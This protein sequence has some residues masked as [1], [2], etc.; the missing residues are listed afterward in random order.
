MGT[1]IYTE[2]GA[3]SKN[4][5]E[6]NWTKADILSSLGSCRT[7]IMNDVAVGGK[8]DLRFDKLAFGL[9]GTL[10]KSTGKRFITPEIEFTLSQSEKKLICFLGGPNIPYTNTIKGNLL[11]GGSSNDTAGS[12]S[13][14]ANR[15]GHTTGSPQNIFKLYDDVLAINESRESGNYIY[16]ESGTGNYISLGLDILSVDIDG[17]SIMGY[18]LYVSN[19]GCAFT[20]N[21]LLTATILSGSNT[22]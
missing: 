16:F 9:G 8:G 7:A 18:W 5:I 22:F 15:I 17:E 20:V 12:C 3:T 11:V 13:F 6:R 10:D 1:N 19:D 21:C 4:I 2:V 14:F